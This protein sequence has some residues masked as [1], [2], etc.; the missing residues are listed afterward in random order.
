MRGDIL[1]MA[2]VRRA[3]WVFSPGNYCKLNS[4]LIRGTSAHHTDQLRDSHD[5]YLKE[6]YLNWK[7]KP[8]EEIKKQR[9][10]KVLSQQIE[11]KW[12]V[13][14]MLSSETILCGLHCFLTLCS[15]H[16]N[17]LLLL[18]LKR[19]KCVHNKRIMYNIPSR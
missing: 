3:P 16:L 14:K 12:L 2:A 15:C 10:F 4:Y 13:E 7:W 11:N 17:F 1:E 18:F 9:V 5:D 19:M 8:A 6:D